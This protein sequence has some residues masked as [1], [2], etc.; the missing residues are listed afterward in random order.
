[1]VALGGQASA[2]ATAGG[3]AISVSGPTSEAGVPLDRYKLTV[4]VSN[5]R[6]DGQTA[7][8]L[9]LTDPYPPS[10][11]LE[12]IDGPV[13]CTPQCSYGVFPLFDIA[14][15]QTSTF[16]F[17]F[18]PTKYGADTHVFTVSSSTPAMT[19][20]M[21]FT[22]SLDVPATA[23]DWRV[24]ESAPVGL[25]GLSAEHEAS[26]TNLG[27]ATATN[28][29]LYDELD[30]GEQ[31][32][33]ATPSQGS[34]STSQRVTFTM[35]ECQLGAVPAGATVS[36]R[37]DTRL[38]PNPSGG[39][40]L[41]QVHTD[42]PGVDDSHISAGNTSLFTGR[43]WICGVCGQFGFA[44]GYFLPGTGWTLT[45]DDVVHFPDGSVI[46]RS[47]FVARADGRFVLPD[48]TITTTN[49]DASCH[50]DRTGG[51]SSGGGSS[52]TSVPDLGVALTATKAQIAPAGEDDFT[53][54][55]TNTGGAGSLETHV[56]IT[57]PVGATLLG[58][59]AYD[60]GSGCSGTQT[61]DCY[62]DYI[63]N[64]GSSKLVFAVRFDNAGSDVVGVTATADR[65]SDASNN[66][67]S[68]TVLVA[69]P[70]S[71]PSVAGPVTLKGKTLTGSARND[72]LTGTAGND[73]IRG[74]AGNDTLR[75]GAG[76]DL[77]DG[78]TGRDHL[79]GGAG[80][81]TIRAHDHAR[82]T[83]DCGPGRDTVYADKIDVVAR[84]CEIVHRS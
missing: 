67:A 63:P 13:N 47:G 19:A 11:A 9:V 45:P 22:I 35:V 24:T 55:I 8:G 23:A 40:H 82:D 14:A 48:G 20:T 78:G 69:A 59:P 2:R 51:G 29:V 7:T 65:D 54:V 68:A 81:D 27:P 77:L 49:P 3:L 84:N 43:F 6:T 10:T 57:L 76:N 42:T 75:G 66:S 79:Y 64:G 46:C 50:P 80:N 73:S 4:T 74:G 52:G 25:G 61:I 58:P 26:A 70:A 62:L 44:D 39:S 83:I 17:R 15:G 33:S 34:C 1:M 60:R 31:F 12:E 30:Y 21:T 71:S 72:A 28:V 32:V 56:V 41:A 16:T 53:A 38:P 18:A 5:T 36:V 37:V